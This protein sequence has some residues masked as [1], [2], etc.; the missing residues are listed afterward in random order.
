MAEKVL[1]EKKKFTD[2]KGLIIG[3]SIAG[4]VV[5]MAIIAVGYGFWNGSQIK[6]YALD[7]EKIVNETKDWSDDFNQDDMTKLAEEMATI[8]KESTDFS[9]QVKTKKAPR[10]AKSL[11]S[12]MI[13]YFTLSNKVAT[14][15]EKIVQWFS[16]LEKS[17]KG[18]GDTALDASTPEAMV[19]SMEKTKNEMVAAK[20]EL[21]SSTP[22][23]GLEEQQKAFV[24]LYDGAIAMYDK[25]ITAIKTNDYNALLTV[26]SDSTALL[27]GIE[28]M[29]SPDK[30]LEKTYKNDIDRGNELE[31]KITNQINELK[32]VI[33]SF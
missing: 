17:M 6:K 29:E 9:N 7:A 4:A 24:K 33:F 21:E 14:D 5:L 3:L 8:K 32:T 18:L 11:K 1:K 19:A 13:E 30:T 12:D 10:R 23:A 25:L 16:K 20:K 22:P 15:M 28:N 27:S 26:T 31:K 2:N